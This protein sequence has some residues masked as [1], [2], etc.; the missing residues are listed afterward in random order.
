[1]AAVA[2]ER[3]AAV[4]AFGFGGTNFT[5]LLSDRHRRSG[6]GLSAALQMPPLPS[7]LSVLALPLSG[8]DPG[9]SLDHIR[10][11]VM[12]WLR[13]L[14]G[15]HRSINTKILESPVLPRYSHLECYGVLALDRFA[16]G[17][18]QFMFWGRLGGDSVD[19]LVLSPGSPLNR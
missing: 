1:M 11:E 4:S 3:L 5:V 6:Q 17:L 15:V 19:G 8:R 13:Q 16:D 12:Q 10:S 18:A 2:G 14:A 9:A 7:A